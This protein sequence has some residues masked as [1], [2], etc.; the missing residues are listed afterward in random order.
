MKDVC[1][2][3]KGDAA[4]CAPTPKVGTDNETALEPN[5]KAGF[6]DSANDDA[7][8]NEGAEFEDRTTENGLATEEDCTSNPNDCLATGPED[9][10]VPTPF[11]NENIGDA[12]AGEDA[13]VTAGEE[14]APV[15]ELGKFCTLNPNG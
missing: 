9:T 15:E 6:V 13:N 3:D 14:V 8:E 7:N 4:D 2:D 11:P 1:D 5:A 10:D 12:A